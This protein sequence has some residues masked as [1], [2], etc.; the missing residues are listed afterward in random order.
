MADQPAA[1]PTAILV[2]YPT[3]TGEPLTRVKVPSLVAW[4][5]HGEHADLTRH[6]AML[7]E[8]HGVAT[9]LLAAVAGHILVE[10]RRQKRT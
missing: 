6:L 2:T 9:V 3:E 4:L 1:D 7:T 5:K 8:E 10:R